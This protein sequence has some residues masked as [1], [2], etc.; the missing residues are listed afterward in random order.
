MAARTKGLFVLPDPKI[1]EIHLKN[2]DVQKVD[3]LGTKDGIRLHVKGFGI[4]SYLSRF[5][6]GPKLT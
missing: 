3:F 1:S 2:S 4:Y 6:V 5:K